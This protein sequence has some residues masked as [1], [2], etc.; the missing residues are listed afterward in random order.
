MAET[1]MVDGKK[2]SMKLLPNLK[3][4]KRKYYEAEIYQTSVRII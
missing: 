1:G 4:A 2:G 3:Q